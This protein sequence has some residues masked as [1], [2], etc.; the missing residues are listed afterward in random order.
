MNVSCIVPGTGLGYQVPGTW[1]VLG[2]MYLPPIIFLLECS[3]IPYLVHDDG[4]KRKKECEH[5]HTVQYIRLELIGS[6]FGGGTQIIRDK[7]SC[8]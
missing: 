2:T 6:K 4:I 8:Q 1:C 7:H 3:S 5:K